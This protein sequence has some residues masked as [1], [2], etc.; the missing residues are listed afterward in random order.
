MENIPVFSRGEFRAK[1]GGWVGSEDQ[2]LESVMGGVL[3]A[4]DTTYCLRGVI[5][6]SFKGCFAFRVFP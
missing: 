2:V 6:E 1:V 3:L 4:W 5:L